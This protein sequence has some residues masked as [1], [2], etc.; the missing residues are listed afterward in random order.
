MYISCSKLENILINRKDKEMSAGSTE[1]TADYLS[2]YRF[3]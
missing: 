2:W 1:Y 3:Y